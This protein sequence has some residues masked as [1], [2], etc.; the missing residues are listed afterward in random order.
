VTRSTAVCTRD[1]DC[2]AGVSID[3][4]AGSPIT[5]T[6]TATATLVRFADGSFFFAEDRSFPKGATVDVA[7]QP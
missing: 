1:K 3:V 2:D 5:V 6:A 7:F 4:P